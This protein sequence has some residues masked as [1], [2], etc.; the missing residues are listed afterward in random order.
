MKAG[1]PHYAAS[2]LCVCTLQEAMKRTS[3]AVVCQHNNFKVTEAYYKGV[4]KVILRASTGECLY[5]NSFMPI[6]TI[7]MREEDGKTQV[8]N[9]YELQ[10]STKIF[11]K[12]LFALVLLFETVFLI[13][14]IMKQLST[15]ALL[16][17]PLGMLMV[18]YA[19]SSVGLYFSSKEVL[20]ILF[21][22]LTREDAKNAPSLHKSKCDK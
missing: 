13:L 5:Y 9:F 17:F 11:M 1:F 8:S 2:Y 3:E 7:E 4:Q 19:L 18:S 15:L 6:V 10:K 12:I 20:R 21:V 16:C 22:T 14:W